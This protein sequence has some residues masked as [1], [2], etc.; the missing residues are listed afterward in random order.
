MRGLSA[1]RGRVLVLVV[2][3]ASLA[4]AVSAQEQPNR[5]D[6]LAQELKSTNAVVV[7]GAVED[8]RSR[9][10][11]PPE[12]LGLYQLWIPALMESH[13]YDEVLD[14]THQG[15]LQFA[16][17]LVCLQRL[18]SARVKALL[19]LGR[20]EEALVEAKAL[21]N[22]CYVGGSTTYAIGLLDECLTAAHPDKPDVAET[23]RLEQRNGAQ[24]PG[25]SSGDGGGEAKPARSTVMDS[26]R[27]LYD[28]YSE[29]AEL[30]YL[31]GFERAMASGNLLLMANRIQEARQ[32]FEGAKAPP[33]EAA[34]GVIPEALARCMKAED[35]TTGRAEA[36][37]KQQRAAQQSGG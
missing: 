32:V 22:V 34:A 15:R 4:G 18:Q 14:L 7:A 24:P 8:I 2:A 6:R 26:I 27:I 9:L 36:W 31:G 17:D 21:F 10:Y 16:W 3:V 33:R 28:P 25:P 23:F 19:I 29:M 35:G 12:R 37:L 20:N 30:K 1:F 13:R 11:L 5:W